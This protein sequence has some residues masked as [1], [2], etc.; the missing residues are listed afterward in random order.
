MKDTLTKT[1]TWIHTWVGLSFGWVLFMVFFTGTLSVFATEISHWMQPELPSVAR[2]FT[3][4]DMAAIEGALDEA[5]KGAETW[6]IKLP[7]SR[8]PFVGAWSRGGGAHSELTFDAD[9]HP[10]TPRPTIGGYFFV[11]FHYALNWRP[12]GAFIVAGLSVG[13]LVFLVSGV[14][15]HKRIFKDFFTFRP[16]ASAQR[17]WLDAHNLAGVLALPFHVMIT[18]TGIV[19]FHATYVPAALNLLYGG[20]ER[21]FM[22]DQIPTYERPASGVAAQSLPLWTFLRKGEEKWGE[23]QVAHM[24]VLSPGDRQASVLLSRAPTYQLSDTTPWIAFDAVSGD[25]LRESPPLAP[26]A[27]THQVMTGLH[28]ARFGG[29]AVRWLYFVLGLAG[30]AMIATGLILFTVKRQQR[31]GVEARSLWLAERLNVAA[32]AGPIVASAAYLWGNRLISTAATGRIETEA[33]VFFAALAGCVV[34]AL[35]RPPAMAW[36]EQLGAA[37]ALCAG[38]PVINGATEDTGLLSSLANE[39]WMRFGVDAGAFVLGVCIAALVVRLGR[40]GNL[41]LSRSQAS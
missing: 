15:I 38:V 16:Q 30:S 22:R 28:F 33:M 6:I 5:G 4:S 40:R 31:A 10:I 2:P 8:M 19:L 3:Q 35:C 7:D 9:M 37:A 1:M 17:A 23:G 27:E 20:N 14:V 13:M 36:R 21:A 11:H 41:A 26:A 29:S 24:R 39:D 32:I 25:V 12:I 34:H 18:Y